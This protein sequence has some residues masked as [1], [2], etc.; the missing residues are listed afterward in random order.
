MAYNPVVTDIIT[1][2]GAYYENAGQNMKR[3][4]TQLLYGFELIKYMTPIKTED[5]IYRMAESEIGYVLQP[6]QIDFSKTSD[7]EFKPNEIRLYKNKIDQKFSP[8]T[9]EETWLG[10]LA[11]ND[12][13]R[14]KW[15]LIKYLIEKLIIPQANEDLEN[16]IFF[17]EYKAPVV[18][19]TPG[20]LLDIMDGLKKQLVDGIGNG[21]NRITLNTLTTS[22][23]FDEIEKFRKGI[24]LVYR[25]KDL[26]YFM[27]PTWAE[28][29]QMGKRDEFPTKESLD[30]KKV[31]FSPHM[32][33]GIPGMESSNII[34]TT[35]KSNLLY[36]TKKNA[37]M[38]R[39]QI[40]GYERTVKLM[41]D[42]FQGVGFGTLQAVFASIPDGE[43][44]SGSGSSS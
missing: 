13:D 23:I 22:N 7:V 2:Y 30:Y 39:F 5:T 38:T 31:D 17:A 32:V 25:R 24:S 34:F 42:F 19:G 36:L 27:S 20:A 43:I 18:A 6:F 8:D 9:V 41:S 10:F 3:L 21:L 16:A 44:G 28:A 1:E 15:P 26:V 14:A 37:N 11:S 4:I 35:P 29:Y 33:V 12:V 40:E